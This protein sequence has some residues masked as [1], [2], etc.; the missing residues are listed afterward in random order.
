MFLFY[1]F[2]VLIKWLEIKLSEYSV[3]AFTRHYRSID[4]K[5]VV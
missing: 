4:R 5:S 3:F 1:R 2:E